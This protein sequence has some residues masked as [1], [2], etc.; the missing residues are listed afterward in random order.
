MTGLIAT[1]NLE[2]L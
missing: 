2:I 1:P